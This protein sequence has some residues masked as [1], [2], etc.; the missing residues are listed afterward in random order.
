MERSLLP[1]MFITYGLQ[2]LDKITLG[3]AAVLGLRE[4][5]V[6]TLI[7]CEAVR[8]STDIMSVSTSS[9][10]NTPGL[11]QYSTSGTSLPLSLAHMDLSNCPSESTSLAQWSAG[12]L[13]SHV[14]VPSRV[15]Q[16]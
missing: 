8:E 12:R 3:Y 6:R 16:V 9:D 4:D 1:L 5:A 14:T 15:S 7:P 11:H 10:N 2:Y 13:S